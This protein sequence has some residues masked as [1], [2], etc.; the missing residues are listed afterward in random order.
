MN[1]QS[2]SIRLYA[3]LLRLYPYKF[4]ERFAA[5]MEHDFEQHYNQAREGGWCSEA[6]LWIRAGRDLATSVLREHVEHAKGMVSTGGILLFCNRSLT[7]GR[8][9]VAL[10]ICFVTFCVATTVYLLPK[11]Y[12]SEARL[13]V[14][15]AQGRDD[16]YQVDTV[17]EKIRSRM[18]LEPV[19]GELNLTAALADETISGGAK[20]ATYLSLR[21]MIEVRSNRNTGLL[22]LRVYGRNPQLA[23][24]I[25]N[26]ITEVA[27]RIEGAQISLLEQAT[28]VVQPVRP[29]VPLNVV[30]GSL[31]SLLAAVVLAG[32]AR[33]VLSRLARDARPVRGT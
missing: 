27:S 26:K 2:L 20:D 25:A 13:L 8:L 9:W 6:L 3:R 18:V 33:L 10:T 11:V 31:V 24:K 7:F 19:I 4:R 30:I 12:A 29:N 14:R 21:R 32:V 16:A 28:P 17:L 23:S 15:T 1:R 5:E 22:E